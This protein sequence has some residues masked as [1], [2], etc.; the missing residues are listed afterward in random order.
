MTDEPAS[1]TA[2]TVPRGPTVTRKELALRV[3][4]ATGAK[5]K[6]VRLILEATLVAMSE[7]LKAGEH[8]RL[9]PFGAARVLRAADPESGQGMRVSLRELKERAPNPDRPVRAAPAPKPAKAAPA[10]KGPRAKAKRAIKGKQTL[11]AKDEA[12]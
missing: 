8:L 1:K 6:D 7:A 4:K 9:P 12:D 11:A 10:A 3:Q 2:E 5:P